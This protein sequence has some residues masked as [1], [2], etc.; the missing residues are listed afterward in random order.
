MTYFSS[1]WLIYVCDSFQ[2]F[3]FWW[4]FCLKT[5][6]SLLILESGS[7]E[8]NAKDGNDDRSEDILNLTKDNDD[9][10]D[11]SDEE[12]RSNR[13]DDEESDDL[14]DDSDDDDDDDLESSDE[15]DD[16]ESV[17]MKVISSVSNTKA[18]KEILKTEDIINQFEMVNSGW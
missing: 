17:E 3:I 10:I 11:D 7:D 1:K 13:S 9:S 12:E 4:S 8:E 18:D 16:D 14:E 2:F 15:D 6:L 5:V